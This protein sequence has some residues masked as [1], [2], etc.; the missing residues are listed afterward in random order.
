MPLPPKKPTKKEREAAAEIEA[1]RLREE[2]AAVL[3]LAEI[4]KHAEELRLR[5]AELA[6]AMELAKPKAQV[7]KEMWALQ[8]AAK[9][10]NL[11][12]IK[13][14]LGATGESCKACHD[15]FRKD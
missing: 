11:D 1:S 14:A 15:T 7:R 8:A 3:H 4:A 10:G 6:V 12:A 13:T 5:D 2:A 9:S